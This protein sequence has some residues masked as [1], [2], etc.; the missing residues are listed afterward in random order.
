MMKIKKAISLPCCKTSQAC[1]TVIEPRQ[2]AIMLGRPLITETSEF[3]SIWKQFPIFKTC[4]PLLFLRDSVKLL[5]F[6]FWQL[7]MSRYH[8]NGMLCMK[9]EV[10]WMYCTPGLSGQ[11]WHNRSEH[12]LSVF[13]NCHWEWWKLRCVICLVCPKTEWNEQSV[14]S[15]LVS[16]L[17]YER[18][19]ERVC[20]LVP[21]AEVFPPLETT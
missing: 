1:S 8:K 15:E 11:G 14:N 16:A 2:L 20:T 3:P 5:Y 10:K 21:V 13:L 6:T 19:G 18:L 7:V 9:Y 12:F 17:V 4:S